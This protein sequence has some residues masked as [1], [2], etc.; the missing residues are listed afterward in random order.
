M[1]ETVASARKRLIIHIGMHKTGSS[2]IQ[3]FFSRNRAFL[4]LAGIHYPAS[5]GADGRRQPKHNA[6]FT[7]ISHEADHGAPHPVLGPASARIAATADD[8][9]ASRARIGVLSAEGLSGERPVFAQA[10]APLRERF[11]CRIVVL[12]RRPDIWVESFYK[13]MVLSREVRETRSFHDFLAAPE[14]RAHLDYPRIISWWEAA[15]GR[16]AVSVAAFEPGYSRASPLSL[17]LKAADLPGW[18][19]RAPYADAA[20]NRSPSAEAVEI[21]RRRNVE[22]GEI[23]R[24]DI[25]RISMRENGEDHVFLTLE[26][27]RAFLAA[28][29]QAVLLDTQG[30][31]QLP[32][33]MQPVEDTPSRAETWM[34]DR[35]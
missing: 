13:Q 31:A 28:W 18:L 34:A 1:G 15:F 19:A 6:I 25:D 14:T 30:G 26:E 21:V 5:V 20:L 29:G 32:P 22:G 35:V 3:H 17:F 11:D 10:L 8:L 27:R 24:R 23:N 4:R 9:A 16:D 12:V 2:S 33:F 7:A